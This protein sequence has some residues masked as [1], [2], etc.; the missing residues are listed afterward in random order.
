MKRIFL[1]FFSKALLLFAFFFAI[2]YFS[3]NLPTWW[4]LISSSGGNALNDGSLKIVKSSQDFL[5][6][7]K[8]GVL[9]PL[10]ETTENN[11][12]TTLKNGAAIIKKEKTT[13]IYGHSSRLLGRAGKYDIAFINLNKLKAGD[14]VKTRIKNKRKF[15]QVVNK[16]IIAPK[17]LD[18]ELANKSGIFLISCWPIGTDYRRILVEIK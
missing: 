4:M 16:K 9:V 13:L 17:K 14:N 5:A 18:A 10:N 3:L 8:I 7:P 1:K 15:Y 12:M 2:F 11:L 6:I